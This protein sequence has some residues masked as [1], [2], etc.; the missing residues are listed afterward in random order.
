MA[1]DDNENIVRQMNVDEVADQK[2]DEQF[3]VGNDAAICK[4]ISMGGF[5]SSSLFADMNGGREPAFDSPDRT[6]VRSTQESHPAYQ[7]RLDTYFQGANC[8]VDEAIDVSNRDPNTGTC[9]RADNFTEGLRP[10]CWFKPQQGGTTP[11]PPIGNVAK[12]PSINGQENYQTNNI[13]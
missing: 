6:I 9:N 2:C 12:T 10:L 11:N 3:S 1:N 8:T 13:I 5:A 4:R 7:C